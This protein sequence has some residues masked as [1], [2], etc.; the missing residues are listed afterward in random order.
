MLVT[1][2][3]RVEAVPS[4]SLTSLPLSPSCALL[5]D[6]ACETDPVF[7]WNSSSRTTSRPSARA[8]TAT[9]ALLARRP[10]VALI[11]SERSSSPPNSLDSASAE[12]L[13]PLPSVRAS[14]TRRPMDQA[15]GL[16]IKCPHGTLVVLGTS[17]FPRT[18]G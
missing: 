14:W 3:S 10:P 8:A 12:V 17:V 6:A 16:T 11:D 1:L 4:N 13:D 9:S 18:L 15:S 2:V 7:S 5:Q